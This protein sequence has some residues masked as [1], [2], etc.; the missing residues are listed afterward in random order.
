METNKQRIAQVVVLDPPKAEKPISESEPL[1]SQSSRVMLTFPSC[2]F[3][4]NDFI[5][6]DEEVAYLS[7]LLAFNLE[8]HIS[9]L[10]SLLRQGKD[11]LAAV[12]E[13]KV[14]D[15]QSIEAPSVNL[16]L[17]V[18]GQVPRYA[19]HLRASFI[20]VPEC[21]NLESFKGVSTIEAEDRQEM[22]DL[23]LHD[24]FGV[25]RYLSRGDVFN[26]IINWNCNSMTC[27]PCSQRLQNRSDNIVY[28]KVSFLYI[29]S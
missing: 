22:I 1:V 13:A 11:T 25:D 15:E 17:E 12:F 23:A 4:P 6:L 28:F 3:P 2:H 21:G 20:K 24:Y 18:V 26:V 14:D 19:S 16:G 7:P 10:K 29:N 27:I 5:R 8:L 9:C